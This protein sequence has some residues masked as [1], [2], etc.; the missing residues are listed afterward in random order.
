MK[1]HLLAAL[2]VL[3][4]MIFPFFASAAV[5]GDVNN[6]G[7]ITLEDAVSVLRILSG[8][9]GSANG[10]ASVTGA[11]KIGLQDALHA[12]QYAAQLRES[13]SEATG[14]VGASGGAVEVT[15]PA[16]PIRG[17]KV[18]VPDGAL[19]SGEQITLSINYTDA[20]PGPLPTHDPNTVAVSK[21]VVLTKNSPS[22]FKLPVDVVVPYSDAQMQAGDVPIVAYWN[23]AY[24]EYEAVAVK[25]IDTEN[26]LVTFTTVHFS[27]FVV[28]AVAGL[29][30]AVAGEA[31]AVSPVDTGFRPD[32][33]GFFH[34]NNNVYDVGLGACVGMSSYSAWYFNQKKAADGTGLYHKYRQGNVNE[35]LDD[36]IARELL[37]RAALA[38]SQIWQKTQTVTTPLLS[39]LTG[40]QILSAMKIF[41]R[42]QVL[43]FNYRPFSRHAVLAYR[44]DNVTRQFHIYDNNY[45]GQDVTVD[46]SSLWGLY[47]YSKPPPD[48]SPGIFNYTHDAAATYFK[49]ADFENFYLGAASAWAGPK[50]NHIAITSPVLNADNAATVMKTTTDISVEGVVSGGDKPAQYLAYKIVKVVNN[51]PA[52]LEDQNVL[53]LAADGSF[54]ITRSYNTGLYWIIFLATNDRSEASRFRPHAYAGLKEMWLTVSGPLGYHVAYQYATLTPLTVGTK[55]LDLSTGTSATA[56]QGIPIDLNASG[57]LVRFYDS[58]PNQVLV[59]DN[60]G[61]GATWDLLACPDCR[62]YSYLSEDSVSITDKGRIYYPGFYTYYYTDAHGV[63]HEATNL[64]IVSAA[65]AGVGYADARFDLDGNGMIDS[66]DGFVPDDMVV[67]KKADVIAFDAYR[68]SEGKTW[69]AV[70]DT[71]G[72]GLQWLTSN[73]SEDLSISDNGETVTFQMDQ[74]HDFH[75]GVMSTKGGTPIDLDQSTGLML[76]ANGTGISPD[77]STLCS[78]YLTMDDVGLVFIN[79][80]SGSI[81]KKISLIAGNVIPDSG[82]P[83]FIPDGDVVVFSGYPIVNNVPADMADLFTIKTDGT[84]L[85]NVTNTAQ[86]H[87]ME[88]VVVR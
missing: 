74:D 28:L 48:T 18:T 15:D 67:A 75:A 6:D 23:A 85:T 72:T 39:P 7:E 38:V 8:M 55:V 20:L 16:S 49:S 63:K 4:G 62:A 29:A 32:A 77:G 1:R 56:G 9:Q 68:R 61:T 33:D 84:G 21:V 36:Y 10:A 57:K 43:T 3:L 22:D 50:F 52:S 60:F 30:A 80:A 26:K 41:N 79:A 44:F 76:S 86:V 64:G 78:I 35:Y 47:N 37:T 42:P 31:A 45:P 69:L 71:S 54:R 82:A 40:L 59:T 13:V 34:P 73:F 2:I 5:S 17:T 11:G 46:W 81:Q 58:S 12:L 87:E 19:D 83:Q 70:V 27:P 65:D 51:K 14:A 53:D 25:E 24:N 66:L 88:P